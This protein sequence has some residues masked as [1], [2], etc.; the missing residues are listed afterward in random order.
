MQREDDEP[1]EE[2]EQVKSRWSEGGE[3]EGAKDKGKGGLVEGTGGG[4]GWWG[5]EEGTGE[6]DRWRGLRQLEVAGW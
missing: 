3:G 2:F 6:G 4:D 5:R 1:N